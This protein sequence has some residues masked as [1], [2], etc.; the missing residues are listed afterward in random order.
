MWELVQLNKQN[1]TFQS[2]SQF[3][4]FEEALA[5][6]TDMNYQFILYCGKMPS[7]KSDIRKLV[8]QI[9]NFHHNHIFL[10]T[11]GKPQISGM[12]YC[13]QTDGEGDSYRIKCFYWNSDN[14]SY[15]WLI[16]GGPCHNQS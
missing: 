1:Y 14:I 6:R 5:V 11:N 4:T 15:G 16:D 8:A 13:E 12:Y 3:T 9:N 10:I 7:S 2:L